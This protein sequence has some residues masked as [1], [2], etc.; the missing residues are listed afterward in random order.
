MNVAPSTITCMFCDGHFLY[1]GPRY[2]LHLF[3]DHGAVD[4]ANRD[5]IIRASE[6]KLQTGHL[7]AIQEEPS[8][9]PEYHHPHQPQHNVYHDLEV[10]SQQA[11]P[12]TQEI[13]KYDYEEAQERV[14]YEGNTNTPVF[15]EPYV[16]INRNNVECTGCG[17]HY[18]SIS[19][20]NKHKKICKGVIEAQSNEDYDSKDIDP[21]FSV[22]NKRVKCISCRK[23]YSSKSSL[24]KHRKICKGIVKDDIEW[25]SRRF[26]IA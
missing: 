17:K 10:I 3:N 5:F 15:K 25:K 11:S 23:L 14:K 21:D 8:P 4:D 1:P 20:L 22:K 2:S 19:N 16:K 6:F 9:D 12:P 18:F 26:S 7:P 24:Q 13:V